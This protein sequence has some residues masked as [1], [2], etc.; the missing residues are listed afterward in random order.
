MKWK[1][2]ILYLVTIVCIAGPVHA[3]FDQLT[4]EV[5]AKEQKIDS[6]G[7]VRAP[8]LRSL[9]AAC[10]VNTA[11]QSAISGDSKTLAQTLSMAEQSFRSVARDLPA[12]A[13]QK[14]FERTVKLP[15][16]VEPFG[17]VT[18]TTT[19]DDLLRA[20]AELARKSADAIARIREGK[21]GQDE[22]SQIFENSAEISQLILAFY[23]IPTV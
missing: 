10:S 21:G 17:H 18:V 14:R 4:S 16:S 19:G 23:G 6:D 20:I 9:G 11:L 2:R 12:L 15:R 13:N 1:R 8:V 3:S 7:L 22:L 5:Q